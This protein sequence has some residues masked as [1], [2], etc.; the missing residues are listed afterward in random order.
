MTVRGIGKWSNSETYAGTM[1][2]IDELV[3]AEDLQLARDLLEADQVFDQSGSLLHY[4]RKGT[5]V[6]LIPPKTVVTT[7]TQDTSLT[8]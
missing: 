2:I 8:E 5:T 4:Y 7:Q 3:T 1:A 6:D